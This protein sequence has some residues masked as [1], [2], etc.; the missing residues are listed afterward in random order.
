MAHSYPLDFTTANGIGQWIKR[1][2]D[3][4]ENLLYADFFKGLNKNIG[5]CFGHLSL[6]SCMAALNYGLRPAATSSASS[7]SMSNSRP[8][9][10]TLSSQNCPNRLDGRS[11]S[12][13]AWPCESS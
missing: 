10:V 3:Q 6:P 4:S 1:I 2:A 12:N 8:T 9:A 7:S 5:N 11:Y 13:T